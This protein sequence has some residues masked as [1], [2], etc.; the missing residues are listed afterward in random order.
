MI[1]LGV[2][3][4]ARSIA[5]YEIFKDPDGHLWEL[6]SSVYVARNIS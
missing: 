6:Q 5:F 1:T 3:D 4:L 2:R